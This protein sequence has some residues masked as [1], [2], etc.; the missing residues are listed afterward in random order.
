VSFFVCS[1]TE[2]SVNR[3]TQTRA[4]NVWNQ[5]VMQHL[6]VLTEMFYPP[7]ASKFLNFAPEKR[8]LFGACT[9]HG[10]SA[11]KIHSWIRNDQTAQTNFKFWVKNLA[12]SRIGSKYGRFCTCAFLFM[13]GKKHPKSWSNFQN[14]PTYGKLGMKNENLGSNFPPK[15]DLWPFLC[16]CSKM[17]KNDPKRC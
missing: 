17:A 3:F 2:K 9:N 4:Q 1:L 6:G 10:R 14:F 15:V 7:L 13:R 12:R 5:P 16:I 11:T 8:F